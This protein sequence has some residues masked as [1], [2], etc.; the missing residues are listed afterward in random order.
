MKKPFNLL[1]FS[2]TLFCSL[3]LSNISL[4]GTEFKIISLQHR[5]AQDLLPTIQTLVGNNGAVTGLNNQLIIRTD[6][7]RMAEIEQA[8]AALD[9]AR[10]NFKI[11]VS[12]DAAN[13]LEQSHVDA[14]GNV[15][16]GKVTIGNS[17]RL[18]TANSAQINA[19]SNTANQNQH[20]IQFISVLE[21]E[22][23]FIR[24]GQ[25]VPYTQDW[26]ALT[27]R[28]TRLQQT[29]EFRDVTTGFAVILRRV[30]DEKNGTFELK[31]TPRISSLSSVGTIDFEE[32]STTVQLH[33]GEWFD[34]GGTMQNKDE[35]SRKILSNQNQSTHQSSNLMIRVD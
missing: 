25:I 26:I 13:Q 23:A 17:R 1:S 9:T 32:L 33:S 12:H 8:I 19:E 21:G 14:Q 35:V 34:I 3:L 20:D 27:Y 24:T 28:Y 16:I 22:R 29:I 10:R 4:A 6:S 18:S 11:T 30:G 5:M 7:E 31:I 2:V 15:Q